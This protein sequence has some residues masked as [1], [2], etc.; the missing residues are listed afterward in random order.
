[1]R[2]T[3]QFFSSIAIALACHP[4]PSA[5]AQ[6]NL[7]PPGAPAPTMK[8]LAQV[9]PRFPISIIPTNLTVGGSYY[10]V[11]NLTGVAAANG[12]EVSAEGVSIDL[13]GFSLIGVNGSLSGIWA[14]FVQNF[15]LRNGTV[16]GWGEHGVD[17]SNAR[18][19]TFRDL[20]LTHNAER[21]LYS[22]PNSR[23]QDCIARNN[24]THGFYIGSGSLVTGCLAN[25]NTNTGFGHYVFGGAGVHNTV[26][27]DCVASYNQGTGMNLAS[28]CVAIQN[29]FVGNASG[30]FIS[31]RGN[32]VDENHFAYNSTGLTLG[33]GSSS[34]LVVRNSFQGNT[35]SAMSVGGTFQSIGPSVTFSSIATNTNPFANFIQ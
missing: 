23:V 2:T 27:R 35:N 30:M 14:S 10:L 7:T 34:N 24:N 29:N 3:L 25:A 4:Q 21:G 26:F 15:S 9:E 19:A 22:G 13:C 28:G 11:T 17:T 5:W 33:S 16:T 8:T 12:I 1:M 6:G 20:N 18:G 32:R 31:T